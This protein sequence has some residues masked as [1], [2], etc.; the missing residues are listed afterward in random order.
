MLLKSNFEYRRFTVTFFF[1]LLCAAKQFSG[2]VCINGDD[3]VVTHKCCNVGVSLLPINGGVHVDAYSSSR[4]GG[5]DE[6]VN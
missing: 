4:I 2:A 6:E 1:K 5:S 3:D